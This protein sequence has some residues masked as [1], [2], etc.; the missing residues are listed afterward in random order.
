[1]HVY[2]FPSIE[3]Y[4]LLG[5]VETRRIVNEKGRF[6]LVFLA[7]VDQPECPVEAIVPDTEDDALSILPGQR[8]PIGETSIVASPIAVAKDSRVEAAARILQET[9]Q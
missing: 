4:N 8:T 3:F 5:L 9:H 7:P 2:G 1:M 6:T